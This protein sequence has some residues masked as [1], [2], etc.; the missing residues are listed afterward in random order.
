M[1]ELKN[2]SFAYTDQHNIVH[3][4]LS[5][6]DLTIADH[7]RIAVIGPSGCGKTTLLH[8]LAGLLSP[9]EGH[10]SYNGSSLTGPLSS[11]SIILQEYGLFPWKT[12]LQNISLPLQLR[13]VTRS[14]YIQKAQVL[15]DDLGLSGHER[16]FPAALSGGQRQRVAIARS[17]ISDPDLLLMDEP[18]SALDALTRENMQSLILKLCHDR[19]LSLVLVTHNIEEAVYLGERILVFLPEE[20][21]PVF[22]DNPYSGSDDYRD[23][24]AFYQQCARLRR[25]ISNQKNRAGS[26]DSQKKGGAHE[27]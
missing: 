15:I 19:K 13:H 26:F 2:V 16:K 18:F 9:I 23:T 1:I 24:D 27:V 8:L 20:T 10:I 12:V 3:P 14:E 7:E 21:H 22:V 11:I 5:N 6:E 25:M 4:I 17:L